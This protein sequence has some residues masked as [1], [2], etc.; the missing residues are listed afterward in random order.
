MESLLK[1][2]IPKIAV[3]IVN[4]ERPDDT[5]QCIQSVLN[6]STPDLYL[7]VVDNG[8]Q[9]DSIEQISRTFPE[10]ELISLPENQGFS[11]GYNV[12]IEYALNTLAPYIFILNND[13]IITE[14]AIKALV[15][16]P[17]DVSVPKILFFDEKDRIWAAGARW[18]PFPPSV[19]MIG[20]RQKDSN[21][22]SLPTPLD[23]ATGCALMVKRE[24]LDTIRGFD[25]AFENYMEDY[26]FC[27][28][29]REAGF[30]I[31]YVPEAKIYHKVSQTLGLSSPRRWRYQ[32]K[33]T[34]LFYRRGNRFPRM[35][36][37]LFLIWF[38]LRESIK[39]NFDILPSFWKGVL[40]GCRSIRQ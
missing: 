25:P 21:A 14:E 32:G 28:N 31:G 35:F 4:W 15:M 13:T 11:G 16:S 18:R 40:E 37:W 8:S 39:G 10:V 22:Y 33:N 9:D 27:F 26:D 7:I 30:K 23:Y 36:L 2:N 24:V 17:W 1:Q 19:T 34:V 38:S 3:V 5:I 29:V 6:S 20:Y 12:G